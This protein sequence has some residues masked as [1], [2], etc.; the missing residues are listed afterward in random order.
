MGS[1]PFGMSEP[2]RVSGILPRVSDEG[3]GCQRDINLA[4]YKLSRDEICNL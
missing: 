2:G 3:A 1:P 4:S